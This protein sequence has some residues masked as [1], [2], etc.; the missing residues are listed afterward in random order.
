MPA[1]NST[2]KPS[3]VSGDIPS[4]SLSNS[5]VNFSTSVMLSHLHIYLCIT[6]L[7]LYSQI[8]IWL[9]HIYVSQGFFKSSCQG[10]GSCI[11]TEEVTVVGVDFTICLTSYSLVLISVR[12]FSSK[13][14]YDNMID[15]MLDCLYLFMCNCHIVFEFFNTALYFRDSFIHNDDCL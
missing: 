12:L 9:P 7:Y 1:M 5:T 10:I 6:V 4:S 14:F 11:N 15:S 3:M 13:Q 2:H 8:C